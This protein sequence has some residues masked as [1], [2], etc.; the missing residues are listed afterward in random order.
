[1]GGEE[2]EGGMIFALSFLAIFL[3]GVLVIAL[4]LKKRHTIKLPESWVKDDIDIEVIGRPRKPKCEGCGKEAVFVCTD[5][6]LYFCFQ[7]GCPMFDETHRCVLKGGTDG[8]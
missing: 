5:C 8:Q 6:H 7:N 2:E 1:L 3:L 4:V